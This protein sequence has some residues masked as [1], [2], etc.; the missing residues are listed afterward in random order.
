MAISEVTV[1]GPGGGEAYRQCQLESDLAES[2]QAIL[3]RRADD[4]V[5]PT[6]FE[7]IE[8]DGRV[9]DEGRVFTT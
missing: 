6:N 3:P 1:R 2:I 5:L 9:A 4:D 7:D 8:P